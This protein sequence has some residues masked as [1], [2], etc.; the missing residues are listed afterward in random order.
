MSFNL[1]E[2]GFIPIMWSDGRPDRTG[3]RTA[4]TEAGRIRQIAGSNP[5]DRVALMRLLLAILYWCKGDAPAQEQKDEIARTGRFPVGWL[6]RIGDHR[7]C[8]NLFGEGLRDIFNP[9]LR[10]RY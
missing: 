3:I 2:E 5:M 7:E 8:F 6:A 9:K 1:L 10:E 4:L